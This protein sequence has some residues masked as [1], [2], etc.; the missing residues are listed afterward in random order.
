VRSS[1]PPHR[2]TAASAELEADTH[3]IETD[4]DRYDVALARWLGLGGADLDA[5]IGPVW[6]GGAGL[7]G[8][9][10]LAS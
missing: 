6:G 4:H 8:R 2:V 5:R 3:T 9:L 10:T 7:G 1:A